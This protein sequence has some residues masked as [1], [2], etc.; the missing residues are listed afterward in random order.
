[1]IGILHRDGAVLLDVAGV[2]RSRAFATNVKHGLVDIFAHDQRQRLEALHDL[3]N[4]LEHALYGL[5]LVHDAVEPEPPDRA[6]AE[7]GEEKPAQR[8]AQRVAEAPLQRLEPE[9]GGIRIVVPLRHL[10]EMRTHQSGQVN[11]HGH[12]E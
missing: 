8:V 12:F 1:M 11:G 5:V 10:D 4:V 6:A 2:D 7:R 9:L 3:V